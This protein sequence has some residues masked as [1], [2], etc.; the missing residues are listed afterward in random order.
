[1]TD[2]Q[3]N[4]LFTDVFE[5]LDIYKEYSPLH[6]DGTNVIDNVKP[7]IINMIDYIVKEP[8]EAAALKDWL[9]KTDFWIA[10]ASTKFHGNFKGGLSLHTVMVIKQANGHLS[11]IQMQSFMN[12]LSI[13]ELIITF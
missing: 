4:E 2:E 1:M 5:L 6:A 8:M 7:A 13:Q 3:I 10:P 11:I 9:D 12:W